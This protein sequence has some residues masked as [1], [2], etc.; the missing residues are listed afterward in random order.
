MLHIGYLIS[1]LFLDNLGINPVEAVTHASGEWGLN[2]L[3]AGLFITPLRRH[4]HWNKL[5]KLRRFIGLWS[6][7]YLSL[8]VFTFLLF[9]HSFNW[10]SI[11]EDIIERPYITVGFV[12]FILMIPLAITSFQH[13]QKRMGKRWLLLHR[14]VYI[15]AIMGVIHYWWLVKADVLQPFLYFTVLMLLLLDRLYW[16]VKK[17]KN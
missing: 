8:H 7:A 4:F 11:F 17:L 1:G 14:A 10:L 5:L 12:G 16:S 9:D 15:I 13:L 3:M 2:F 6:F